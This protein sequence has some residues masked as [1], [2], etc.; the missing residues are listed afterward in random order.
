MGAVRANFTVSPLSLVKTLSSSRMRT[1][2]RLPQND[3]Q[4]SPRNAA[5]ASKPWLDSEMAFMRPRVMPRAP[6]L[7]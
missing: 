4:L 6:S 5:S 1:P 2:K 7:L 3:C